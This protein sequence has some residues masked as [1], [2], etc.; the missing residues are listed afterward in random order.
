MRSD[1][2]FYKSRLIHF[3]VQSCGTTS[4][5]VGR[6]RDRSTLRK[7]HMMHS[8]PVHPPARGGKPRIRPTGKETRPT[9]T[10][11]KRRMDGNRDEEH[12]GLVTAHALR[13]CF[14]QPYDGVGKQTRIAVTSDFCSNASDSKAPVARKG[15]IDHEVEPAA[16]VV[17]PAAQK[18][19]AT[20]KGK[21]SSATVTSDAR[22]KGDNATDPEVARRIMTMNG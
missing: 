3:A 4:V 2:N 19:K 21:T 12:L 8:D 20:R 1:A 14:C 16:R 15:S 11:S 22:K 9:Q 6:K 10:T 13:I 18:K 17:K 5:E 7:Q